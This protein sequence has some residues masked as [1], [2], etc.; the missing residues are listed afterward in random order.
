[1]TVT[2]VKIKHNVLRTEKNI[3]LNTVRYEF[4]ISV[5][6]SGFTYS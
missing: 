4:K 3:L 6:D 2:G 1:V 5:D